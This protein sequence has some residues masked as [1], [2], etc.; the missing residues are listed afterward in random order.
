MLGGGLHR[1]RKESGGEASIIP[2]ASDSFGP[3]FL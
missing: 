1:V 3:L 2:R